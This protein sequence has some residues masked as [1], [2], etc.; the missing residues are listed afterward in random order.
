MSEA[1]LSTFI[2]DASA[3]Q[4]WEQVRETKFLHEA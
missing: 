1:K 2:C 3:V 4:M